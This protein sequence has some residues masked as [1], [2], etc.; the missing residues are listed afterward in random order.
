MT[1]CNEMESMDTPKPVYCR[2]SQRRKALGKKC[3]AA[4]NTQ[5]YNLSSPPAPVTPRYPLAHLNLI[6][7]GKIYITDS[8][9]RKWRQSKGDSY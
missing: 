8:M 5:F 3:C 2:E 1:F 7:W 6:F 9:L 4:G